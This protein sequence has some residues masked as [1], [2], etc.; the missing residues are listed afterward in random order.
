M[1]RWC[2]RFIRFADP[3][4]GLRNNKAEAEIDTLYITARSG[5]YRVKTK[6]KG[7]LVKA[8]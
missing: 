2:A 6:A 7:Q 1:W 8:K 3:G 4:Y 5:L